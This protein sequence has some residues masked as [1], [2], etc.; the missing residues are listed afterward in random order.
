MHSVSKVKRII[1]IKLQWGTTNGFW[2]KKAVRRIS[3]GNNTTELVFPKSIK[4]RRRTIILWPQGL[5]K[6][7]GLNVKNVENDDHKNEK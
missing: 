4:R 7:Y 2:I 1:I 3:V 5:L 6:I